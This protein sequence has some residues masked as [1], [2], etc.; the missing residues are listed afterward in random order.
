MKK[1]L[2][3]TL[4]AIVTLVSGG[5]AQLN[6]SY[7]IN[8]SVVTGGSNY[9]TFTAAVSALTSVGVSGPVTFT[10]AAGTYTEQISIPSTISG[11]SATNTI[12]FNGGSG[13]ASTRI[14]Q[15]AFGSL[16]N[17]A[18]VDLNGADYVTFRNL[19][20]KSTSASYGWGF[21]LRNQA[22]YN[23]ID[24]CII[25]L[26]SCTSGTSTNVLGI[27]FSNSA[28]SAT[29]SA[30]NANYCI[31]SN[32]SIIG[33]ASGGAYRGIHFYGSTSNPSDN[34]GNQILNNIIQNFY[35]SGIYMYY[36]TSDIIIRG[37]DISRPNRTTSTTLYGIQEQYGY[38]RTIDGNKIHNINGGFTT[39]TNTVYGLYS[40]NVFGSGSTGTVTMNNAIY[41]MSG[42]GTMYGILTQYC[43]YSKF[44]NNSISFDLSATH[45]GTIFGIY[46]YFGNS[47]NTG[48]EWKNNIVSVTRPGSGTR[49]GFYEGYNTSFYVLDKNVYY[50]NATGATNYIGYNLGNISTWAAYKTAFNPQE[51]N[52]LNVNPSYTN[53]TSNLTPQNC[54][55]DNYGASGTGV[56]KDITGATR[57][58]IVDIGA[59]EF[60][61]GANNASV[62]GVVS[63]GTGI[64]T[65]GSQTVTVTITNL[66]SATLTSDSLYWWVNGTAQTPV[67]WTGSVATGGTTNVTLGTYSISAGT[68]YNFVVRTAAPNGSSDICAGNDTLQ[69]SRSIGLSGTYTIN[70]SG[71]GS[72]NFTTFS[73]AVAALTASGVCGPVV[74][75]V[76]AATY[77]E[78]ISIPVIS[79]TSATNTITFNGGSGNAATRVLSYGYTSTANYGIVDLNGADYITFKNITVKST[80]ASYG[81]GFLLRN[82][83]DYNTI[84]SCIID[85]GSVTTTGSNSIGICFSG[86]TTAYSTNGNHANFCTITNNSIIGSATGGPYFGI[87]IYAST[88]NQQ[89]NKKI[90]IANNIIQDFYYSGIYTYFYADS[91]TVRG[92][93]FSRPNRTNS[94]TLYGINYGYY[95]INRV[96]ENNKIH[97]MN[98]GFTGNTNT[99]YGL[100]TTYSFNYSNIYRNNAIY[101]IQG[102]GPVYGIYDYYCYGDKLYHNTISL[103][104]ATATTSAVYGIYYYAATTVVNGQDFKNNIVTISKP[105]ISGTGTRYAFYSQDGSNYPS[106]NNIFLLTSTGSINYYG[107][108]NGVNYP[109]FANWQARNIANEQNS[110]SVNPNFTNLVSN[111]APTNC[112]ANNTGAAVGVT[113]DINGTTRS[114]ALPDAG[115]YEVN[116]GGAND[117]GVTMATLSGFTAG[118]C[119][120]TSNVTA[121]IRNYGSNTLTSATI[122]WSVNGSAQTPFSYSGSLA[123]GAST[124]VSLGSFTINPGTI[125]TVAVTGTS[126]N[127]STDACS[128]NDSYTIVAGSGM[129]GTYTINPAG[130]GTSNYASFTAAVADLNTRGVCGPVVFNVS[131]GTYTEQ[132][133]IPQILGSSAT[134][135]ITFKSATGVASSVVLTFNSPSTANYLVDFNGADYI[136]FQN[137]TFNSINTTYGIGMQFRNVAT[138]DSVVG[139]TFNGIITTS[140]GTNLALIFASSTND[141]VNTFIGNTFK[142]G[143]YGFYYVGSSTITKVERMTISGNTFSGQ[144][145][146][147][148][149]LNYAD[150]TQIVGNTITNASQNTT[151]YMVYNTNALNGFVIQNNKLNVASVATSGTYY[152]VYNTVSTTPSPNTDSSLV[153]NNEIIMSSATQTLYGIYQTSTVAAY[154][155]VYNNSVLIGAA[156]TLTSYA[157]Y[158]SMTSGNSR[159]LNNVLI[160]RRTGTTTAWALYKN[161]DA[162]TISNYNLLYSGGTNLASNGTSYTTLTAWNASANTPDV[163]SFSKLPYFSNP[164][165]LI[166][167]EGCFDNKGTPN[168]ATV[169]T[170]A[171][172]SKDI[173]G[174]NRGAIPDFGAYEF[175][176]NAFDLAVTAVTSPTTYSASPQTVT[177]RVR[178]NGSTAI[179]AFDA[180]YNVNG[181]TNTNQTFTIAALNGCDSTTLSF[182]NQVTMPSGVG[183][184]SLAAFVRGNLNGS[185]AD[186]VR[187]NDTA[188]SNPVCNGGLSGTYTI[189]NSIP[190]SNTNFV[191]FTSAIASLTSCGVSGPVTFNVAAGTYNEQVTIP[192]VTGVSATN[193]ITF[194]GGA[195]NAATRVIQYNFASTPHYGVVRLNG[196][197]Y[198]RIKNLTVKTLSTS[199]GWGFLINNANTTTV[200]GNPADNN[201]IDNCIIDLSLTASASTSINGIVFSASPTSYTS[202]GNHSNNTVIS[203]NLIKG[204]ALGGA[205]MGISLYGYTSGSG[206]NKNIQIL[207]NTIQDF[208]QAGIYALYYY[209][210]MIIRGNDISRPNR[211]TSTTLY[212]IYTQYYFTNCIVERNKIHNMNGNFTTNTSTL[213]GIYD[214]YATNSQGNNIVRNNAIYDMQGNGAMY[215]IYSYYN[216]GKV[217]N[218]TISL[219]Y[220]LTTYTGTH[221][222]IYYYTGNIAATSY[223]QELKNNIISMTKPGGTRYGIYVADNSIG[224]TDYNSIWV[225]GAGST[226]YIGYWQPTGAAVTYPTMA[227]WKARNSTLDQNSY[228]VN[229]S[230]VSLTSDPIPTAC[231]LDNSGAVSISVPDDLNGVARGTSPDIGA[232]EFSVSGANNAAVT[233]LT[234]PTGV[235]CSG[236]QNVIATLKNKGSATLTTAKIDWTVN[237]TPQTQYSWSGTLAPGATANV[238]I[239]TLNFTTNAS[240]ALKVYSSLPN[241]ATDGCSLDDTLMVTKGSGMSGAYTIDA[242]GSGS[243]NFT[244]FTNAI[245]AMSTFGVCGPVTFTVA[246]G[247]YNG[248]LVIPVIP[249]SSALNT[250]TFDGGTGNATTR[251]ITYSNTG[252]SYAGVHL[253]GADYIRLQNL[254]IKSLG[255]GNNM[256]IL[257][258]NSADYNMVDNCIV[259]LS[260]VSF[261]VTSACVSFSASPTSFNGTASHGNYN[262]VKNS[263]LKGGATGG[264][265]YGIN[266]YFGNTTNAGSKYNSF[267]NNDIT[268]FY[269]FGIYHYYGM[270]GTIITDNRISRPTM[271]SGSST[272]YGIYNYYYNHNITIARNRI[273]NPFGG[274]PGTTSTFYGIYNYVDNAT[275]P[276]MPSVIANNAIY[277]INTNGQAMGIYTYNS[278]DT[279]IV[280]NTIVLDSSNSGSSSSSYGLYCQ[281]MYSSGTAG[282]PNIVRNNMVYLTR[283]GSANNA[284]LY[285]DNGTSGVVP[286]VDNNIYYVGGGSN[287]YFVYYTSTA[288][289]I[290]SLTTWKSQT[291]PNSYDANSISVNPQFVSMATGNL[292]PTNTAANNTAANLGTLVMNDINQN[293]RSATPDAGAYE[294]GPTCAG[295]PTANGVSMLSTGQPICPGT[296]AQLAASYDVADSLTFQWQESPDGTNWSNVSGGSGA[297]TGIYTTPGIT[298]SKY[299]RCKITCTV[300]GSSSFTTAFMVRN[301]LSGTYTIDG[302]NST[303]GTNYNSFADV[304]TD[305]RTFG[306]CGNVTFNVA[307]GTYNEQVIMGSILGLSSSSQITFNGLG[308]S[309]VVASTL[310][311]ATDYGVIH[312]NG[313]DYVTFNNLTIK[314]DNPNYGFGFLISNGADYVTIKNCTIDM[315]S[316][317]STGTA[318]AG[319]CVSSNFTTYSGGGI[320]AN[321]LTIDGNRITGSASG[322]AYFGISLYDNTTGLGRNV[323]NVIKNNYIADFYTYGIYSYY[324]KNN[325]LISGNT[326]TRPNRSSSGTLYGIYYYYN[327]ANTPITIEKNRIVGIYNGSGSGTFY[328]IYGYSPTSY[329]NF[330]TNNIIHPGVTGGGAVTMYGVYLGT[331][332][333]LAFDHNTII[334]S[335]TS[336]TNTGTRY[337]AYFTGPPGASATYPFEIKNNIMHMTTPGGTSYGWYLANN[338]TATTYNYVANYN[339]TWVEPFGGVGTK[340]YAYLGGNLYASHAAWKTNAW[341]YDV[342]GTNMDAMFLPSYMPTFASLD[343]LGAPTASLKTSITTDVNNKARKPATPDMGAVEWTPMCVG[344][345]FVQGTPYQG[346]FRSGTAGDF[347]HLKAGTTVTYDVV[348]ITGY[349]NASF[350]TAWTI[351]NFSF[352]T[353][354]GSPAGSGEATFTNPGSGTGT[355]SFSP[356]QPY[357]DSTFLITFDIKS[358]TGAECITPISRY[359]YVAPVPDVDFDTTVVACFTS[360]ST[361]KNNTTL[362]RG[363]MTFLWNFGD[364]TS[365]NTSIQGTP[366]Y[367][368]SHPGSFS[369]TLTATSDLGYSNTKTKTMNVY[370]LPQAKYDFQPGCLGNAI[371]F[372]NQSTIP[373]PPVSL[374]YSWN[375]GDNTSS[376]STSPSKTYTAIG[377]YNVTLTTTSAQG[378]S[379]SVT[380]NVT[381]FPVPVVDFTATNPCQGENATFSNGTT[382]AYGKIGYSW[383][384]GDGTTDIVSDPVKKYTNQGTYNVKMVAYSEYGCKDSITKSVTIGTVP[385]ATFALT[386]WCDNDSASFSNSS[387]ANGG[388]SITSS[389]S[390]GDL[391]SSNSS[392][393]V[394]KHMYPSAGMYHVMLVVTNGACS[395]TAESQIDIEE[396]PMAY[397]AVSG[398]VCQ[399]NA[400]TFNNLS[401]GTDTLSYSWNFDGTGTSTAMNPTYTFPGAGSFNVVLN[402]NSSNGCSNSFTKSVSVFTQPSAAFTTSWNTPFNKRQ[403]AFY[404]GNQTLNSYNWNFGDGIGTSQQINPVYSY[405]SNGPFTVKLTVADANGCTNE[406]DTIIDF[407]KLSAGN[408]NNNAFSFDVYPNP[409]RGNTTVNYTLE[410]AGEVEVKVY[411]ITGKEITT[412]VNATKQEVGSYKVNFDASAVNAKSGIYFIRLSVDGVVVSKQVIETK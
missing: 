76:A 310:T 151:N 48:Y 253:N 173:T 207:N 320:N 400:T 379:T 223:G 210:G 22:N 152:G 241:G 116:L 395:D 351:S 403:Q 119:S 345:D 14:L 155:R 199:I 251:I 110:L 176:G 286:V 54:L 106:D 209:D 38:T 344:A 287:N 389:W 228:N 79:G 47:S 143:S 386:K 295:F 297:T 41:D 316:V 178:N 357:T 301:A 349:T 203:N 293:P 57:G 360:P 331:V 350:G 248:Q 70:P 37:N 108:Y 282:Q 85:L 340:Y 118:V 64:C 182:T 378:C 133:S 396:T 406:H 113:T 299:Y 107:Y 269:Y 303:S 189:N 271:T 284:A 263:V 63:P 401:T 21:N 24:S 5:F 97:N 172:V 77:N 270:E 157:G 42:N 411:D 93:D 138:R 298:A 13:N 375:F 128:A 28:T 171:A 197:D 140:T 109:T 192:Q 74:F 339:N 23:T 52:S 39:N 267:I 72:S 276:Y 211:N 242:A 134:N 277:N 202:G 372:N 279:K 347:D 265:Y 177:F 393:S 249:G 285:I 385:T 195:G 392:A 288:T 27:C 338:T 59:Y 289:F 315:S 222:G 112:A 346:T 318:S 45:T 407:I 156:G 187:A 92:N 75:N 332:Y 274:Q 309:T 137:M 329:M 125:Y 185:N 175:S 80:N 186:V 67:A 166:I 262:I 368:F 164:S 73:A 194:D 382:I 216:W 336:N 275:T 50:V 230:F 16:S 258:A 290:N 311:N 260:S 205:Y 341:G 200:P 20:I 366:T 402:V 183:M 163:N 34:A 196:A 390:F 224:S 114:S 235:V 206:Y 188:W 291:T 198:I 148:I 227:A 49:Y 169:N 101:D 43:Y 184:I 256:G 254:T 215:G 399:G 334:M 168:T 409:F 36:W 377:T 371:S 229:P 302:S 394:I 204:S 220:T 91:M 361:I 307:A 120:G 328:G 264:P 161:N 126:P 153:A 373:G 252:T 370:Y 6:G 131:A 17:Y 142:N 398:G 246:A 89:D 35:E 3:L 217:M 348:P 98:G 358:V 352:A 218:N 165:A 154:S 232:Y 208:Y 147:P 294:W 62:S 25:D 61:A 191:S 53:V 201:I 40:Y 322:G 115:A 266:V 380:K 319:I 364:T 94:T 78:Q 245:T 95:A 376:S 29:S 105:G 162:T 4:I 391:T 219:D 212:G 130:S 356:S 86:S 7:T 46:S 44:Y 273:F 141:S 136:N 10:V 181:G 104:N 412:L 404:A 306:V 180:G 83:A 317:T 247:T 69:F 30:N 362:I 26:S 330:I 159:I 231:I 410:R 2:L 71:S 326:I 82:Q 300:S 103:D 102:A 160:N 111:L 355:L 365:N 135:Y 167:S 250:V 81:W 236:T 305:L 383:N 225:N 384:F 324:E 15:F 32:N 11:V 65:P 333:A 174:A 18:V 96:T 387:T 221:Y 259:D 397:F 233:A 139:C 337:G 381:I 321:Y 88:S 145:A 132:I 158:F 367:T 353:V 238:T 12:T 90:L 51:Q 144:Y 60:S 170:L 280:Y 150:R 214:Y 100:S 292:K 127:S 234:A 58:T 257:F 304:L 226:N 146:S 121:T 213:Y 343:N 124:V 193:T 243:T 354:N 129:S 33:G 308:S 342:N 335:D 261:G 369:V 190:A 363:N 1:H 278:Y 237:G 312:L 244:S 272:I 296:A 149:Y 68:V 8:G 56:T 325:M 255:T 84:D 31:I 66:G 179:T 408:M 359:I 122:N 99:V 405:F 281:Y 313:T 19:T 239:G 240:Y 268:D 117:V 9:Q 87:S 323:N 327:T 123:S 55:L 388:P 374:S 314:A 283:P